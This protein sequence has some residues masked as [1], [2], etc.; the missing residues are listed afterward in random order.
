MIANLIVCAIVALLIGADPD[1]DLDR[2]QGRWKLVH[3][4]LPQK[5]DTP[6]RAEWEIRGKTLALTETVTGQGTIKLDAA[7]TVGRYEQTYGS[8]GRFKTTGLYKLEGATFRTCSAHFPATDPPA[9]FPD[10]PDGVHD[11]DVWKR[12]DG[13]GGGGI[14]GSWKLIERILG[15]VREGDQ[16]LGD[17]TMEVK[18]D[19]YF[20]R[21]HHTTHFTFDLNSTNRPKRIVKVF[22]DGMHKG[23]TV[24]G[25]YRLEAN[26]LTVSFSLRELPDEI[27]D[28]PNRQG[29]Y[30]V[31]ERAAP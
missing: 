25:V 13:P 26:R 3:E 12:L 11:F 9:E 27:A 10:E 1:N 30:Q 15:K 31:F 17:F 7:K 14:E 19:H 23:R 4:N 16:E 2:M 21:N 20:V 28:M 29:H 18:G 8:Q 22:L 6:L 5:S 24:I